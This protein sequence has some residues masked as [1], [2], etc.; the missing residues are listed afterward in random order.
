MTIS[1][2]LRPGGRWAALLAAALAAVHAGCG[3][4]D[5]TGT[6]ETFAQTRTLQVGQS[7]G[8]VFGAQR[9]GTVEVN[10]GW[11]TGANDIQVY[12]TEGACASF[13]LLRAGGCTVVASSESPTA[14]PETI[15]FSSSS[16]TTY[17]VFAVNLGPGA[18][19]VTIQ[20]ILR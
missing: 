1:R 8:L 3:G 9:D 20:I 18:D 6:N 14:K 19:N 5:T 4:S 16:G 12:A 7:F 13:D 15:T 2:A 17:T 10:V 11:S